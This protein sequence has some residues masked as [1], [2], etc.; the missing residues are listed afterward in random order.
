LADVRKNF[1][2]RINYLVSS[3]NNLREENNALRESNHFIEEILNN[4]N[5]AIHVLDMKL[6]KIIWANE[7]FHETFDISKEEADK[8]QISRFINRFHPDDIKIMEKGFEQLMSEKKESFSAVF[9]LRYK[10]GCWTQIY[11]TRRVYKM[12]QDDMPRRIIGVSF[13]LTEPVCSRKKIEGLLKGNVAPGD[14]L[15]INILSDRELEIIKLIA[16]GYTCKFIAK[17][18]NISYHTV[19]THR[20]RIAKKINAKNISE[21]ARFAVENGLL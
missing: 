15:A 16:S 1:E 3:G 7:I 11:T 17:T 14:Q 10:D 6:N 19:N 20:K 12:I 21:I 13:S 8:Y 18:L 4:V 9:R 2:E 5:V